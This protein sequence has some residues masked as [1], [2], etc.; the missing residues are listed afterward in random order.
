[1]PFH[2]VAI[3][4]LAHLDAPVR[5]SSAEIMEKLAPTFERLKM[6]TNILE[7]IAGIRARHLWNGPTSPSSV[8][9]AAAI[10]AMMDAAIDV[11]QLGLLINTSVSRDYLEP[12]TASIVAGKLGVSSTCQNFDLSNACLGFLNGMDMAARFI[13]AGEVDYALVVDGETAEK[14]YEMTMQR[15]LLPGATA[16]QVR[17][18]LAALT[19]GSGAAAMVLA[20]AD[21]AVGSPR[22]FGG[23]SRSA[24]QWNHLCRGNIDH[25]VTDTK[26]LLQEGIRLVGET[27]AAAQAELGWDK[28]TFDAFAIHQVSRVHTQAM[29]ATLGMDPAK[30][31]TTFEEHGNIG[32]ASLPIALSKLR[33]TGRLQPG[34]QVALLGI[35]S[36]LNCSMARV[37]W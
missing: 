36:G 34:S 4:G 20:R 32:P 24:T 19:L 31:M 23:V 9:A 16:Q 14:V 30:V 6:P 7:G 3:A 27:F 17:E 29:V 28:D 8:A 11:G 10:E 2:N 5:V 33:N 15:L 21:L 35:G 1:M 13:E 18:E 37:G 12:S 22:Y 26:M 25:M